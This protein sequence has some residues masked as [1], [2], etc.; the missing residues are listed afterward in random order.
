M[1][2]MTSFTRKTLAKNRVRTIVTILGVALSTLLLTGVITTLTS[3]NH[4]MY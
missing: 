2:V 1:S 3:L 4:Y